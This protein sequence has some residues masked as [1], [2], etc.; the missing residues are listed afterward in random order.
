L[1][2]LC[3]GLAAAAAPAAAPLPRRLRLL[4]LGRRPRRRDQR[5]FHGPG[6]AALV[7]RRIVALLRPP[8]ATPRHG[9][10]AR[11]DP[12]LLDPAAAIP[13]PALRLR[14]GPTCQAL[15]DL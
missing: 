2:K 10:P 13:R 9:R 3:R 5:R 7:A 4:P 14:A 11:D 6:A 12:P 1:R 8:G 15:P